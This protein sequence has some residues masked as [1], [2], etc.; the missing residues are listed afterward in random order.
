MENFYLSAISPVDGRYHKTTSVLKNIFS[1]YAFLKLKVK[2]EIRWLQK[3]SKVSGIFE[4]QKFDDFTND[5][6]NNIIKNFNYNDAKE[7]KQIEHIIHHDTKAIEY[8][9]KKK[10][11]KLIPKKKSMINFIHFS[12]TSDDINNLAYASMM[13]ST[14]FT[15]LLPYWEKII[16]VIKNM[17]IKFKNISM[18][19]RTHGQPATPTTLGKEMSN[20]YSRLILQSVNL[21]N[22]KIFGKINGATGNYNAHVVSYPDIDWEKVSES[23][24]NDLGFTWNSCTTQIEPHDYISEILSCIIRFNT[25]LINL[26]QDIWGYITLHYFNQKCSTNEVGSST[27]PHKINPIHFE[28]SEG[29]LGLSNSI[30]NHMI[31][32]L[33]IS[34]W[35]RD[36][37][38]STVLRNLGVTISY[39][40]IAYDSIL[41]GLNKI[42]VNTINIEKDLKDQWQLLAEPIQ[43]VMRRFGINDAYEKLK[44]LTQNKNIDANQL[45]KYIDSLNIPSYEKN[46]LK[47]L[48]PI[49]YIGNA[50]EIVNKICN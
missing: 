28:K 12:C 37:S 40:I 3:L 21:K 19:S 13:K 9:L 31:L 35:Q 38:D 6:L 2:I 7:I 11:S 44:Q 46:K 22:T 29:N 41:F 1:E 10:I 17:A 26:N 39:S 50:V 27:M 15:V 43:M 48:T 25:I 18:V 14:I 33:P 8:F 47:K 4:L 45:H 23:F 42:Q 5:A 20:F 16:L 36:L 34:R 30:M 32:K 24:V 49:N